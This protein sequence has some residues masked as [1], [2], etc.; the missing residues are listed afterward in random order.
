MRRTSTILSIV[1]I[2][3][4][5]IAAPATAKHAAGADHDKNRPVEDWHRDKRDPIEKSLQA[6]GQNAYLP[7]FWTFEVPGYWFAGGFAPY[8]C[9]MTDDI[10]K[11]VEGKT[12]IKGKI[13]ERTLPDGL[14]EVHV[15]IQVRNSPLTLFRNEEMFGWLDAC[16]GPAP[17]LP[18]PA[19]IA[20]EGADGSFDYDL[21]MVMT[22]PEPGA[23]IKNWL[24][25][26]NG[27]VPPPYYV[28]YVRI[29]GQGA[30]TF[31]DA[32]AGGWDGF[33]PGDTAEFR[34]LSEWGDD[35][36]VPTFIFE[37]TTQD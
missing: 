29:E 20:G 7:N 25:I 15:D 5:L 1:A 36:T 21:E 9:G 37:V 13:S 23:V 3:I 26:E 31:T 28:S 22:I 2:L 34:Y 16:F 10:V 14:A 11:S 4:G 32:V 30:G 6:N 8:G 27:F 12:K 19:P 33:T 18:L 35:V 24:S 17:E